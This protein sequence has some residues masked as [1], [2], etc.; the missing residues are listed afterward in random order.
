MPKSNLII[1]M[2]EGGRAEGRASSDQLTC[3]PSEP[4]QLPLA[5][6]PDNVREAFHRDWERI[7]MQVRYGLDLFD[8]FNAILDAPQRERKEP[9]PEPATEP[10][11]ERS[12]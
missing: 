6:N 5:L 2:R 1:E 11:R 7:V 12:N 8:H 4:P 3:L 10:R 9:E